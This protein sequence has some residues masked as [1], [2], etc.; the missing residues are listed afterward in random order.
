V[1]TSPDLGL[2][3]RRTGHLDEQDRGPGTRR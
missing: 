1:A 3:Q 2:G